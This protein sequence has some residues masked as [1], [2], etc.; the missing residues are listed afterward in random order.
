MR[1][2][3]QEGVAAA[4]RPPPRRRRSRLER[5]DH[6]ARARRGPRRG[7]RQRRGDVD[8]QLRRA[9]GPGPPHARAYRGGVVWKGHGIRR[10]RHRLVLPG[11]VEGGRRPRLG[12]DAPCCHGGHVRGRAVAALHRADAELRVPLRPL[13]HAPHAACLQARRGHGGDP[14]HGR[15]A[16]HRHGLRRPQVV[17]HAARPAGLRARL[18]LHEQR[19][20]HGTKGRGAHPRRQV[21]QAGLRHH[22]V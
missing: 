12:S 5:R 15:H 10:L 14:R 2:V 21:C 6:A 9:L 11:L 1:G 3:A 17:G 4:R 16:L 19:Q 22:G 13:P 20:H 7:R 18:Q 8:P